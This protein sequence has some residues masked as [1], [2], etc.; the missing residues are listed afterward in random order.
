MLLQA[1]TALLLK[2][3]CA[4][5]LFTQT[6][7]NHYGFRGCTHNPLLSIFAWLLPG[8]RYIYVVFIAEVCQCCYVIWW[9][10]FCALSVLVLWNSPVCQSYYFKSAL[11]TIVVSKTKG[12][13]HSREMQSHRNSVTEVQLHPQPDLCFQQLVSLRGRCALLS[14][15]FCIQ[16]HHFVNHG[17]DVSSF[18]LSPSLLLYFVFVDSKSVCT[19][20]FVFCCYL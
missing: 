14:F 9:K 2:K 15:I 16:D 8:R 19:F 13:C 7:K 11:N 10:S 12:S 6:W 1:T 5:S 17:S 4:T 18:I 3:S 20:W